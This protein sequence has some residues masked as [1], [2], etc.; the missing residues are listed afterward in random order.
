MGSAQVQGKLWG[1]GA[2]DWAELNEPCCTPFYEAVF[3]AIAVGSGLVM[4]DAGC[5]GGSPCSSRLSG[6][7]P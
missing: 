3:D 5:G 7:R 4:L 6:V 1:P 2:R